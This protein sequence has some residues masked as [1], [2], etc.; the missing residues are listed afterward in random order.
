MWRERKQRESVKKSKTKPNEILHRSKLIA[1]FTYLKHFRF[2]L[3]LHQFSRD[4]STAIEPK[5]VRQFSLFTEICFEF[6]FHLFCCWY[7]N[8]R[9]CRLEFSLSPCTFSNRILWQFIQSECNITGRMCAPQFLLIIDF[10]N[11]I[12]FRQWFRLLRSVCAYA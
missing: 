3:S 8:E 7:L 10:V 4:A 9:N 12:L 2:R 11:S 5:T 1:Y 6:F